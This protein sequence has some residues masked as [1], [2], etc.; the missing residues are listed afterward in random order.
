MPLLSL[1][2]SRSA[3]VLSTAALAA[4]CFLLPVPSSFA[5]MLPSETNGNPNEVLV[6]EQMRVPRWLAE[7]VVRAA[8]V[9]NV[10]P[11]YLMAL[12]DKESS[13]LPD[14][15]AR[16][17]SAEGLFQF[18]ESTWLEVLRRYGPKNGYVAEA[19]AIHTVEGRPVVS[20]EKDRERILSLRSIPYLSALMAGE[21]INTHRET[22]AGKVE[23]DLSFSELYM[24]HFLGLNGA[25]RFVALLSDKPDNSAP[26][27][28]PRAAKANRSLFFA[29]KKEAARKTKAL[30][31]T[32][33]QSRI[34]AMINRRVV[35]Y[36][37][38]RGGLGS[39]MVASRGAHAPAYGSYGLNLTLASP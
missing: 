13:L 23:R 1:N 37:S 18:I 20:D 2:R 32:E 3:F 34:A 9:T 14:S 36:A 8:Q 16:T 6:F 21:M 26:K 17:S 11:A 28:F 15:K 12:A 27:A 39:G 38:V 35:R 19:E 7:T 4:A 22:L 29:S 25:S 30:S 10:D 31:V 5:Q 24:A 33:V